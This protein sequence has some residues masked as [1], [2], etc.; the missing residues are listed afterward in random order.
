MRAGGP[1]DGILAYVDRPAPADRPTT[2]SSRRPRDLV[3]SLLVLLVPVLVL[4]GGYQLLSGRTEPVAVD[5]SSAIIAAQQ[6]G[7]RVAEPVGLA[8]DWVPVSAVFRPVEDGGTLRLGYVTPAGDPV[9]VVQS[10]VPADELL[11]GEL[12]E[13]VA[14][15]GEIDLGDA[16][17]QRYPGRPGETALMRRESDR[18]LLVVGPASQTELRTLAASLP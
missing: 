9:Q 6:A 13:G 15:A 7:L 12:P 18:T 1:G 16:V 4:V 3:I 14:P 5:P 8:S 10:T 11:A 17:W 2:R